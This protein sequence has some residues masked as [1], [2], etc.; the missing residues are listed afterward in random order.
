M[1]VVVIDLGQN[2]QSFDASFIRG[3]L[4]LATKSKLISSSLKDKIAFMDYW[5][6]THSKDY[7]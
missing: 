1:E 4:S 3:K 7:I 5:N 6:E 2:S